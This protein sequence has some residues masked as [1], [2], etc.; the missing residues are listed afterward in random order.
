MDRRQE[1]G[2]FLLWIP[3]E[4]KGN[5]QLFKHDP[6]RNIPLKE[7]IQQKMQQAQATA[8]ANGVDF[9]KTMSLVDPTTIAS[10]QKQLA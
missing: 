9:Q 4:T 8:T 10:L 1:V 6:I 5:L 3:T 2:V 7:F